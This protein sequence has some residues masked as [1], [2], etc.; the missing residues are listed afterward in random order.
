MG[1]KATYDTEPGI[2]IPTQVW[3]IKLLPRQG[4]WSL[5]RPRVNVE[6]QHSRQKVAKGQNGIK[7]TANKVQ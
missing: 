2:V 6:R 1:Y 3:V 4:P 5:K 7:K